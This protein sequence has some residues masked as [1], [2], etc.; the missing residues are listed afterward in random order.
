MLA[1]IAYGRNNLASLTP[2]VRS[3]V[4]DFS[5]EDVLDLIMDP[6]LVEDPK[7]V[8]E[9]ADACADLGCNSLVGFEKDVIKAEFLKHIGEG[10]ASDTST[11]DDD[12]EL[13]WRRH[14]A[15]NAGGDT[16][17]AVEGKPVKDGHKNSI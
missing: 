6:D 13:G 5:L 2:R 17:G 14:G 11:D 15:D 8:G 10:E 9:Q 16:I 1:H 3:G 7:T 4:R 12:L